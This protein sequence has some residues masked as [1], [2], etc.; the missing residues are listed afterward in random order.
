MTQQRLIIG[1]G[2][3]GRRVARNWTAQGDTVFALTRTAEH[4]EGFRQAGITPIVGDITDAAS[5][6]GLPEADTILLAVGLDRQAGHSQ[7]DV[8]VGGL[9]NVLSQLPGSVRRLIYI[10][11]TSVYG[12]N[13][14]EWVD[15]SSECRPESPNGQV[16]L[17]AER[18]LQQKV[19]QANILRLAGIYG[20]GRL[21]ARID[22]L[23]AGQA[24]EGNPDGWLNLIHVDDAVAAVLA[25][26]RRGAPSTKYL[27][28]DGHP[29]RRRDY[30]SLLAAMVGAPA[31]FPS[32]AKGRRAGGG[33]RFEENWSPRMGEHSSSTLPDQSQSSSLN[34]R[35]DI[36]RLREELRVALRYP[37]FNLGLVNALTT[38]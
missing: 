23:R 19:P 15:E 18:L 38:R 30:Y 14:G 25:C 20:P 28:A 6:T 9:D 26:E 34:K 7:R 5:L 16:C 10:S 33:H 1:C 13:G 27:V 3:L 8:Y 36:R 29:C 31:P 32:P 22:A 24:P 12:Q 21:V 4:A 35:C 2:Y 17:E 37:R 11:S